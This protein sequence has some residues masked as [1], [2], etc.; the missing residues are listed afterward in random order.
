[1]E[2]G[3]SQQAANPPTVSE[4]NSSEPTFSEDSENARKPNKAHGGARQGAGRKPDP[5]T[6]PSTVVRLPLSAVAPVRDFVTALKR[7]RQLNALDP[8]GDI[9]QSVAPE[10]ASR[11]ALPLFSSKVSAGL[12]SPADNHVDKRLDTNEYLVERPGSTFF[13]TI[14]GRSMIDVGL[15]PGDKAV[16]DRSRVAAIGDIVMAMLDGEFT[17]KTLSRKKDGTLRLLPAN[18]SGEYPAIDISPEASFEIWGVVTGSFRK[19]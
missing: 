19:F 12:P 13:V 10:Q 6:E 8:V 4:H 5:M 11:L 3:S 9:L 7:K 17:I 18:S 1:M 14:Q 16:V 2:H 15:M